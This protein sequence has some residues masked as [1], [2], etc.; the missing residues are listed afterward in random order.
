MKDWTEM[1]R[2]PAPAITPQFG[3]M[4]GVRVLITGSVVAGPVAAT[5]FAEFGAEVIHVEMPGIGDPLRIQAPVLTHGDD[6]TPFKVSPREVPPDQKVSGAWMQEGRN[7]LSMT[8][9]LDMRI[10]EAKQIFYG[11]IKNCDIW[12]E[13]MVW[14]EKLGIT[15][16]DVLAANPKIVIAH[17]S[18]F[19]RPQFG[20]VP[21]HCDRASFDPV[22]QTEGGWALF[23]GFP[24]GPPML[25]QSY[26]N[27]YLTAMTCC[28]GVLMAYVNAQ[29]T[30][31][32][33]VVDIAQ[34][35][36]MT[37]ILNDTIV[38]YNAIGLQRG[39]GGN[40]APIF[41]PAGLYKTKDNYIFVGTF[42]QLSYE[43]SLEAMGIDPAKYP[44]AEAGGSQQAL[45]SPL[46]RE[47]DAVVSEW[48]MQRT[49]DEALAFFMKAKIAAGVPRKIED[50]VKSEH[51]RSRGNFVTYKDETL[52]KD[53][54]AY[55]IVPK[56][57]HTKPKVWRGAPK[58]GQDTD[59]IL[60]TILG[61][62]DSDI[63]ALRGKGAIDK[64][65]K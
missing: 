21:E 22:G 34:V 38:N 43:R 14:L 52:G 4:T 60:K 6:G 44:Y 33:Q 65:K 56:M 3:P 26:P 40:K 46:G 48:M 30:G 2:V 49:S 8:L 28:T 63:A 59:A 42:G 32:G 57:S 13:N 55:G 16:A 35:E 51:Y 18:G 39:R 9:Q 5:I 20:G 1:E 61:Y 37:R 64:R 50:L 7:K 53:I 36:V 15:D 25:A 41:Q 45:N 11:L 17:I 24:D 10:P 31:Q 29:K 19:G 23:N 12:I 47:L 27:D 54:T 62:S 58:M